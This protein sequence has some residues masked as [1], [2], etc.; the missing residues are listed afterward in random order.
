MT[1]TL[2]VPFGIPS[3]PFYRGS[4]GGAT[5]ALVPDVF[6]VSIGGIPFLIDTTQGRGVVYR[7]I[8]LLRRSVDQSQTPSER[9][10][11]PQGLWRRSFNTWHLGK[12]KGLVDRYQPG[13]VSEHL[14][15]CS[16]DERYLNDLLPLPYTEESLNHVSERIQRVQDYLGRQI[17]IENLSSYLQYSH[18]TI[19]EWEFL[20]AVAQRS[21]CGILLD[22]NNIYV[23]ACNHGFDAAQ[24]LHAIPVA[25]V[26]EMHLAGFSDEGDILIDTHSKPVSAQVWTLY[27]QAVQRFGR[28]PTLI[29]W[30][31]DIPALSVLLDEAAH[32]EGIAD[33]GSINVY[34]HTPEVSHAR[35][36]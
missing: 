36:A 12:L 19:P 2:S 6:D 27:E 9:S 16:V 10:L 31:T 24:Y 29:E 11:N 33:R 20:A 22:I 26:G 14:C 25:V 15:W 8:P 30:D 35:L 32:A 4:G 17:L 34:P 3:T 5:S 21:G 7:S 28:C 13:L 23:N 18:S 1:S